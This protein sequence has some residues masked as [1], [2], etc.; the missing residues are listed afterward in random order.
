MYIPKHSPYMEQRYII[1]SELGSYRIPID[2]LNLM[3]ML[4]RLRT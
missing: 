2:A 1:L 4:A 3:I